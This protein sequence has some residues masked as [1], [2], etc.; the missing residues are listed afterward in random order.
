M[1]KSSF[2][3]LALPAVLA[4][5]ASNAFALDEVKIYKETL[6][7]PT[8]L[9]EKPDP[10]PIQPHM[11]LNNSPLLLNVELFP[12]QSDLLDICIAS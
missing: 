11:L 4:A 1:L 12:Y 3:A 2:T 7:I 5:L 9:I 10:N 6:S 8:Y